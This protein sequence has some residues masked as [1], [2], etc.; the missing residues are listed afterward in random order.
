MGVRRPIARSGC[1][2]EGVPGPES[3]S[4][5]RQNMAADGRMGHAFRRHRRSALVLGLLTLLLYY[6]ANYMMVP[7]VKF[8]AQAKH[9]L[10]NI[11]FRALKGITSWF[12][13]V[14]II[15]LAV[16]VGRKRSWEKTEPDRD[17]RPGS[18]AP[19]RKPSL[20]DR[21]AAYAG[22]AQLPFYVLHMAPIVIL[23]FYVVQWEV[24]ALIKYLVI[25]LGTLVVTLVVYDIAVRRTRLT[26][27]LFGMKPGTTRTQGTQPKR[28][29]PG[30]DE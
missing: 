14:L 19:P 27:F 9:D 28:T 3:A 26:R 30:S 25:V 23:G 17:P 6:A 10:P 24:S 18:P 16:G 12:W 11:L 7:A 8:D 21:A 13:V 29:Q 15:G 4:F 1:I 2:A 5:C 20:M 22:E